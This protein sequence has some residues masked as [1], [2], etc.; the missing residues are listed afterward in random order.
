MPETAPAPEPAAQA[1]QPAPIP[2][3]ETKPA[4]DSLPTAKRALSSPKIEFAPEP[5]QKR[6][7]RKPAIN[8]LESVPGVQISHRAGNTSNNSSWSMV[9]DFFSKNPRYIATVHRRRNLMFATIAIGIQ[10]AIMLAIRSI[11]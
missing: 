2:V 10:I 4:P 11:V 1:S 6:P 3:I 7:F 9:Q 8:P 5:P